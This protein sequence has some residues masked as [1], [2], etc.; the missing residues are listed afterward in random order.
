[1]DLEAQES[2]DM[3]KKYE[4]QAK[5]PFE[6]FFT[7]WCSTDDD[8]I[9]QRNIKT[10]ES[11]GYQW[12]LRE[13]AEVKIGDVYLNKCEDNVCRVFIVTSINNKLVYGK[14]ENNGKLDRVCFP[15][16]QV[17]DDTE[18]YERIGSLNIDELIAEKLA[19][20]KGAD[21]E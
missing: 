11:Y 10:I 15:K 19:E 18:H 9:L 8:E 13:E 7:E 1:V 16:L 6:R 17:R 12:R 14:C 2:N 20:L 4:L 21:N 3:S 5:R